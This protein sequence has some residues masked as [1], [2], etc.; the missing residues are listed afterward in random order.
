MEEE[1]P[2]SLCLFA[3]KLTWSSVGRSLDPEQAFGH[4]PFHRTGGRSEGFEE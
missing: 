2:V 1:G 3:E 4:L